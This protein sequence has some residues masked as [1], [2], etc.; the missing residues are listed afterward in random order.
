[1]D[2]GEKLVGGPG[3]ELVE[4]V[5][6]ALPLLLLHH[7]GLHKRQLRCVVRETTP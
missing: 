2:R 4:N 3:Q 5:E 6:V 7:A 1:M